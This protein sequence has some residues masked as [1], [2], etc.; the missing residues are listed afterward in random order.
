MR[1]ENGINSIGLAEPVSLYI[2][3]F[4]T[5]KLSDE[6]LLYLLKVYFD[7]TSSN[8]RKELELDKVKFSSLSAFGHVGRDDLNVKWEKTESKA[9]ELS[10]AYGKAKRTAQVL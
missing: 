8:I 6:D 10:E 5:G 7:F 1:Q 2:D 9:N 3:T 4:G